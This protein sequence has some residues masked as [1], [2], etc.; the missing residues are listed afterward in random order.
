MVFQERKTAKR[1]GYRCP[2]HESYDDTTSAYHDVTCQ[3]LD[4]V[5]SRPLGTSRLLFAT[6]N[7]QT[8]DYVIQQSVNIIRI[9]RHGDATPAIL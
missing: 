2:V 1:H 3:S 9:T 7:R 4:Y 5:K 6:H 8:V